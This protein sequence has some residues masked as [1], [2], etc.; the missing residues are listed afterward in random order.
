MAV[1]LFSYRQLNLIITAIK[2]FPAITDCEKVNKKFKYLNHTKS[3][4]L[5]FYL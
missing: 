5:I 2:L 3:N 1:K 4:Q